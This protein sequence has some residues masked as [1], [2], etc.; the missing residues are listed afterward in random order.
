MTLKER[1]REGRFRRRRKGKTDTIREQRKP[2]EKAYVE[3]LTDSSYAGRDV[4]AV[5]LLY[6][7]DGEAVLLHDIPLSAADRRIREKELY[8][9]D[10]LYRV[11]YLEGGKARRVMGL[12]QAEVSYD[13]F[14]DWI[15]RKCLVKEDIET[16]LLCGRLGQHLSLCGLEELAEK[17]LSQQKESGEMMQPEGAGKESLCLQADAAYYAEL[18]SYVKEARRTLNMQ[19]CAALPPF[20]ERGPFMAGWYREHKGKGGEAA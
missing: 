6:H 17:E 8:R 9:R 4:P 16:R 7:E 1:R 18:L 13:S 14:S 2:M 3:F 15:G 5:S 10:I 12:L 19:S 11:D 20:P